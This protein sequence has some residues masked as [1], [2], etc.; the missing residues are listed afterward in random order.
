MLQ[1]FINRFA[2]P[3]EIY[4]PIKIL[5]QVHVLHTFNILM[6]EQMGTLVIKPACGM[7]ILLALKF[8]KDSESMITTF[9][10]PYKKPSLAVTELTC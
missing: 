3:P 10:R 1:L 6:V 7:L 8:Q 2:F 9:Y 5:R 4:S